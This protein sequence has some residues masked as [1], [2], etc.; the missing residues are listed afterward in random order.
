MIYLVIICLELI[1]F[2][3]GDNVYVQVRD[4]LTCLLS[5]VDADCAGVGYLIHLDYFC[6]HLRCQTNLEQLRLVQV[7]KAS[8]SVVLGTQHDVSRQY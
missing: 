5:L 3:P 2:G 4:Q 7:T 6:Q 8:N 1:A